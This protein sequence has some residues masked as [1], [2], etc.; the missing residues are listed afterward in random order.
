MSEFVDLP[1]IKVEGEGYLSNC[2]WIGVCPENPKF[3]AIALENERSYEDGLFKRES[4]ASVRD[5]LTAFLGDAVGEPWFLLAELREARTTL[6]LTRDNI[7]TEMKRGRGHQ[8]EGVPEILKAR[9]DAI[10]AAIA[11]AEGRA[12]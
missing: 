10:D 8:W 6:S 11:R 7:M 9:L 3:L 4:A 2:M 12:P 5:A 1:M